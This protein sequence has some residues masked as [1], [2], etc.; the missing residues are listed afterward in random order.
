MD[1]FMGGPPVWL[2][3]ADDIIIGK[4][5]SRIKKL[6]LLLEYWNKK[7]F[8]FSSLHH[9]NMKKVLTKNSAPFPSS[10]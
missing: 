3:T 1:I 7:P 6:R 2:Y 4:K 5:C 9:S 10:T 8:V